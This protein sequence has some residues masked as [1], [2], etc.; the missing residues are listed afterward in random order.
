MVSSR[1]FHIADLADWANASKTGEYLPSGFQTEEFIHCC[2][3]E[4]LD[5]VIGNYFNNRSDFVVLELVRWNQRDNLKFEVGHDGA[6]YPHVYGAIMVAD[7]IEAR[8]G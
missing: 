3:A 1:I 7:L 6:I 8:R 4:Q 2:F 5:E